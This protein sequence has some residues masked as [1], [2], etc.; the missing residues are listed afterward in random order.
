MNNRQYK[1]YTVVIS[2]TNNT[3]DAIHKRLDAHSILVHEHVL[4]L[5]FNVIV[6][7]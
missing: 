1:K 7:L 2:N 6:H 3:N 4:K 5:M